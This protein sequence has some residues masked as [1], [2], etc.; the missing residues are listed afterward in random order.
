MNYTIADLQVELR[1]LFRLGQL[2]AEDGSV[3]ASVTF[4]LTN[5]PDGYARAQVNGK[6]KPYYQLMIEV[7]AGDTQHVFRLP[8][9]DVVPGSD[10]VTPK[11][12]GALLDAAW[13]A[14]DQL[15]DNV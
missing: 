10:A 9:L 1:K 11:E 8:D 14:L 15:A 2:L 3:S 7:R 13:H 5:A 12:A 6:P 4:N